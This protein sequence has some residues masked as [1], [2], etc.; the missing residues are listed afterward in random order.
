MS[1]QIETQPFQFNSSVTGLSSAI[2]NSVSA[3]SLSGI[4]YGD[5]S[6]LTGVS[7]YN[8]SDIKALTGNWQST[9][10]TVS[11]KSGNWNTAYNNA[12]YT[13]NGTAN[14]IVATPTGANTGNNS[15]T[16]SLPNSAIF[17]GDVSI[18]GNLTIA[19]SAT[20]INTKNLIVGD[21]IIYFND[22]NYGSNTLDMGIVSHFSQ[23]PLGYNHTGL[24]RR[25]GQGNPGVWTLFSGLT[26]EPASATNIDWNDK[27]I[28]I[29]T[30]SANVLGN[31]SGSYVTVGTGNS[32]QWN[33]TYTTVQNNSATTWNYQGTDLK[34]LSSNWQSTYTTVSANSASW[35]T[36]YTWV[37]SNSANATFSTISAAALSTTNI[38]SYG[39]ET[40]LSDGVGNDDLG[41]GANTL[42]LNFAAGVYIGGSG[43]LTLSAVNG[44]VGTFSTSVSAPALSGVHYGDG[45][46]LTGISTY[47]GSDVRALTGNWQSTYTTV[48]N[49]SSNWNTAYQTVS[50][51]P[52][53]LNQSL[54]STT[55]LIGSNTAN[56][57][58]SEVLGGQ[59]NLASG[60]YSTIVNGFSSCATGYATFVGAGSGI[61]AT[62][63]YAVAVGGQ[64]NTAS[65]CY[66]T[67]GGGIKN[68]ASTKCS[69]VVGGS[70][71]TASGY[72]TAVGGQ[73]NTASGAYATAFGINNNASGQSGV[74]LGC[75]N[76]AGG[77]TSVAL[78]AYSTASGCRSAVVG[79]F[80]NTSSGFYSIIGGGY[81]NYN[82]LR[83]SQIVGGVANHTGGYA[84]SNFV[85]GTSLSGN[86]SCTC[87]CG[88]N[89]QNCFSYP[90][91]SGNIS[92]YYATAANPL[93]AGTFSTA[94]IAATG[95]NYVILN[96]DYSACSNG[97]SA[98]SL[99]V[100]D[101]A[102]N[103]TGYDNFIGGGKLNTASGCYGVVGGG[104]CNRILASANNT[105]ASFSTIG[106]GQ[107][108]TA[109]AYF[110]TVGGGQSNCA[111][112][113]GT[114]GGGQG[115]TA[116][117][118]G[119]FVGGGQ[120]NNSGGRNAAITGGSTNCIAGSN[121]SFIGGGQSNCAAT[122]A[123]IVV[124]GGVS[125]TVSGSTSTIVGGRYNYNP[126]YTSDIHGGT[127]NHTGG[128]I[129][130]NIVTGAALSGNGVCSCICGSGIQTC[131][132]SIASNSIFAYYSTATNPLSS[133]TY[134][135]ATITASG[136]NYVIF[137]KDFSACSNGLSATNLYLYD[138]TVNNNGCFNFIGGGALN[139][140]SGC[141]SVLGGGVCNL[142]S[143]AKTTVGGGV[144]N[145]ATGA[146]GTVSGGY[147]NT[148]S[149]T[150]NFVGGGAKNTASG[151]PGN[152]VVGGL[153]NITNGRNGFIGSGNGNTSSGGY[154]AIVAGACNCSSGTVYPIPAAQF[155]GS[156]CCNRT[157]NSFTSI[158]GGL[159]NTASG[160]YSFVAGG[161]ANDTK[162]FANTFILGT[163]LSATQAN[164]TYVNNISAQGI[165]Y[166]NPPVFSG[167]GVSQITFPTGVWAKVVIDTK[168]T[169]TNNN[170]NTL[171]A[172]GGLSGR[173]TPTIPG[174][175]QLNG[176]IQ[177][178]VGSPATSS[179]IF[180]IYKN[181]AE[182]KRG[183]RMPL[184][185][186]GVGL[187][188][189]Q[190][191]SANGTG[192][193][194]E[195]YLNQ[196]SSST[197][198]NEN[199]SPNVS[200]QFNGVFVRSL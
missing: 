67:V 101:R 50:T 158:I 176:S 87:I 179:A 46:K 32:N 66:S 163:G 144:C 26:T 153:G 117:G 131:F 173:F 171:T 198:Q 14:Q 51:I 143:S 162:G 132:S 175:Y 94:T 48:Q 76:C 79:G 167:Y 150:Y 77:Q 116:S 152:V 118:Y 182:F 62:G 74:A 126:L 106:G 122:G 111:I 170:F 120:S 59:C 89:I 190:I 110:A 42:S 28:V 166:S 140:A 11:A 71:N 75:N 180:A 54:S 47:T 40:V 84:P 38:Y 133:G 151:N 139:T 187:T 100:Y 99:Y 95:T 27:N 57:T 156:G 147:K 119:S 5:G 188:I 107:N 21:N 121:A 130:L 127:F 134:T 146:C 200:P 194:F 184:N 88:T 31:L 155:I 37:N 72:G 98:T 185:T 45:S 172:A 91:T 85:T 181:G 123:C 16:I 55:T 128:Y 135:T 105:P 12:I 35:S 178:S 160:N 8:G 36:A 161:S 125:N 23:A 1:L 124:G 137:N 97:L 39:N 136:T 145:C 52:F 92:V 149:G 15:V 109:S 22:N 24:I 93:S 68:K 157:S 168:E 2:F 41:N 165:V 73:G 80:C 90:F 114:V 64:C 115:N 86:G 6:N 169:D 49:T 20:Y 113:K 199:S 29:D 13:V 83:D 78:G 9:F 192:D 3:V 43:S 65:G 69:T 112:C 196:G 191:V 82:P 81:G 142:T 193:Y 103:N 10:T 108:N 53:T 197:V 174:Y 33:N 102:I 148:A 138:S 34:G 186:A 96:T 60:T 44:T 56:N 141:Y 30:L 154:S 104:L 177:L 19:G 70:S 129:P 18:I 195:L 7:N 4:F 183:G 63:S 58:F 159:C 17:P 25:A 189:N 164:T 61:R